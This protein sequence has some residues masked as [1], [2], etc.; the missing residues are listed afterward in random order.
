MQM[1]VPVPGRF[2][3]RGQEYGAPRPRGVHGGLDFSAPPRTPVSAITDG[4][5]EYAGWANNP[6]GNVVRMI[7]P[8]GWTTG[9]A[10][11]DSF[12]VRRNT[13]VRAGQTL[14]RSGNSGV[15]EGG[16]PYDPHL[17][18]TLKDENGRPVDPTPYANGTRQLPEG[19]AAGRA[20]YAAAL[21]RANG[22][23]G[24]QMA[25][26]ATAQQVSTAASGQAAGEPMSATARSAAADAVTPDVVHANAILLS[27]GNPS[28][29][30]RI[31]ASGMAFI[32]RRNA[33][34][35]E[36]REASIEAIQSHLMPDS[37]TR[38][39]SEVPEA[40]LARLR[41][42]DRVALANALDG[43]NQRQIAEAAQVDQAGAEAERRGLHAVAYQELSDL[44]MDRG[45]FVGTSLLPYAEVLG[46]SDYAMFVN[47]QRDARLGRGQYEEAATTLAHQR[48]ISG[49]VFAAAVAGETT[50]SGR[51][52]LLER[53]TDFDMRL[54]R[55]VQSWATA[56]NGVPPDASQLRAMS[57]A[58]LIEGTFEMPGNGWWGRG[59]RRGRAFE[60]TRSASSFTARIPDDA[61]R[62]LTSRYESQHGRRPTENDLLRLY[63]IARSQGVL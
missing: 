22:A 37:G 9:F 47:R 30:A 54:D 16:R 15:R 8:N 7:L 25:S 48:A 53:R 59:T 39:I 41:P 6:S 40:D 26:A 27:R 49:Q 52:A 35:Q 38:T 3:G 5:V 4:V 50:R 20:R 1:R 33:Q 31:H 14:A 62:R 34:R 46:A 57:S 23:G 42:S 10:H 13:I 43:R 28:T 2:G 19:T 11:L 61:R 21:Q 56:H 18:M 44:S 45:R 58:L 12:D 36:E 17:H 51:A 24:S 60:A 55:E 29:Y 32:A 63:S